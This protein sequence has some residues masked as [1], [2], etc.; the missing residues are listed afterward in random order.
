MMDNAPPWYYDR[1]LRIPIYR[2]YHLERARAVCSVLPRRPD[3]LVDV[4]CDGGTMTRI[5]KECSEARRVVGFDIR[6]ESVRYARKTKPG[7][8]FYVADARNLP[9][10]DCVAD[11]VTLIEVLEHIDNPEDAVAEAYRVLKEGGRAI[12]MV[13][14][15]S[16][17]LFQLVW[18]LWVHTLGRVWRTAHVVDFNEEELITLMRDAGFRVVYVG[19]S[20]MGMLILL[21]ATKPKRKA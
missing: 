20:N 13:P 7:I 11:V 8:E 19:R 3:V 16:S 6:E 21:V 1:A 2:Y 18:F 17:A 12:V 14:D 15:T 9:L 10:R 4:G 5:L